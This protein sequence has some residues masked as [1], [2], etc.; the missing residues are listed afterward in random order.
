MIKDTHKNLTD[1]DKLNERL[2]T[3]EHRLELVEKGLIARD[4]EGLFISTGRREPMSPEE[5]ERSSAREDSIE[6]RFGEYGM[7]WLGNIV[8]LFG[9]LFLTQFLQRNDRQAFSFMLGFLSV[10]GIY[11]AGVFSKRTLPYLSKLFIYN[12]HILLYITVMRL[13][14]F[15]E[16]KIIESD[17]VGY[18]LVLMVIVALV[19]LGYRNK[20]QIHV[21]I[22]WILATITAITSNDTHLMLSIALG[23]ALTSIFFTITDGW[24]AQLAVSII[25]VYAVFFLWITGNP[26]VTR[27]FG[28]I[29]SHQHG[30]IYLFVTALAYS[31]LA[32][33]PKSDPKREYYLGISIL[34]NGFGF[35]FIL[36]LAV[37]GFFAHNYFIYLGL[38]GAFCLGYSILLQSVGTWKNIASMYAIYC[39]LVF[40]ITI[41]GIYNF[42]LAFFLLSIESLLVISMAL[43]FRS[44]FIVIMNTILFLGLLVTYLATAEP[45]NSINF[46]FAIVAL[47]TARIMNW[48][49]QRLEI[50]T[51]M[52]R[53][54]Y[55]L[56]GST[57]MLY[58]LKKAV[59]VHFVTLSWALTAVL[60]FIL[61]VLIKN[62]KYRWLAIITMVL[63]V[64]YLFLVDLKNISLGY[65]II[66]LL[67]ISTISL[68]I[69]IY[70][71]RRLKIHRDE[72][73]SAVR[74]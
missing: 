22:I 12:G 7:A 21:I 8:L 20:S 16:M 4:S 52:I 45:L 39:F 23:I 19:Y 44:R 24:W 71:S 36:I 3:I 65:R 47:I 42:P 38:I 40:S 69:S 62:M 41:G 13:H 57:M 14:V 68:G 2:N 70:Y 51:E 43:W 17:L 50:R 66:A 29:A 18:G 5:R 63:A 26:F 32:I 72:Q 48:K 11:L 49:K 61:S 56:A 35:S 28:I 34:M 27:S 74:E 58:S 55:L 53:N 54:L 10:A 33:L 1:I 37:L 67:F 6:S 9:I 46:S 73:E 15:N 60:F 30:H 64:F 25:L 59:P 31:L